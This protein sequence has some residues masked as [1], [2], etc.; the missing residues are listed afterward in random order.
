MIKEA[1][2][3]T[4]LVDK[5]VWG[6]KSYIARMKTI[7]Q[8]M[9]AD[10]FVC[11]LS[12]NDASMKKKLG[13]VS[14]SFKIN[15]FDTHTVAGAIEYIIAY[16]QDTRNCPVIFYTGTRYDSDRYGEM[17]DLLIEI[18]KKWDIGVID[19]WND[20]EMNAVD[21]EHYDLYMVNGIH[22][23]RAGDREWWTPKFEK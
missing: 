8:H 11:Q 13:E 20:P 1:A 2:S 9:K 4:V 16:A 22:P 10:A 3:S 21:D 18:Q 15:D 17:V 7:D 19:L 6:K 14:N 23:Y 12:T 5:N